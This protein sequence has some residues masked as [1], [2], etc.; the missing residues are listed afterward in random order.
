MKTLVKVGIISVLAVSLY[1]AYAASALAMPISVGNPIKE[2]KS[3][4]GLAKSAHV[5]MV[6]R[7]IHVG[8]NWV[9]FNPNVG[10]AKVVTVL[11]N[12]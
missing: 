9:A 4:P 8:S 5:V 10:G 6:D 3:I 1:L 2:L 12:K 11:G 7:Q